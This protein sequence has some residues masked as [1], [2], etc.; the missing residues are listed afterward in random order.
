MYGARAGGRSRQAVWSS[1][2][3]G[4]ISIP[5]LAQSCRAVA[6]Q[7]AFVSA[8]WTADSLPHFQVLLSLPALVHH[9]GKF[10]KLH[11]VLSR[12]SDFSLS[13]WPGLRDP[14][15]NVSFTV[16]K[17]NLKSR[18]NFAYAAWQMAPTFLPLLSFFLLSSNCSAAQGCSSPTSQCSEAPFKLAELWSMQLWKNTMF[19]PSA[20]EKSTTVPSTAVA[21]GRL[22]VAMMGKCL[23]E[24]CVCPGRRRAS[25][26][27][28]IPAGCHLCSDWQKN[29]LQI[30]R[31]Y[32]SKL[33]ILDLSS[34]V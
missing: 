24:F 14:G 3:A 29:Q 32:I 8:S 20:A 2:L 25:C 4:M 27:S 18:S 22:W 9:S 13:K 16:W 11:F 12:H 19:Q 31:F 17:A 5:V 33:P 30:L 1:V 26:C 23:G 10:P 28:R 21:S 15:R 7:T 34:F 6:L